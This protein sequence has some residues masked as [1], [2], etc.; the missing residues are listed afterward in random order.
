MSLWDY[1]TFWL[2]TC[3]GLCLLFAV[4]IVVVVPW[5]DA[6]ENARRHAR[7]APGEKLRTRDG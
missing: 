5:L 1:I 3:G 4:L 7:L 6:R 2:Y